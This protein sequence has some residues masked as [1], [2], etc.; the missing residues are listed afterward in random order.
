MIETEHDSGP[1][2]WTS[3]I[4]VTCLLLL[5]FQKYFSGGAFLLGLILYYILYPTV[6]RLVLAGM[7]RATAAS[8]VTGAFLALLVVRI[9]DAAVDHSAYDGLADRGR[10][11][12]Q[13]GMSRWD[14]R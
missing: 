7:S 14:A 13:G 12:L 9:P 2:V 4:A 5:A 1:V 10:N 6:Q 3:I 11:Y 8:V